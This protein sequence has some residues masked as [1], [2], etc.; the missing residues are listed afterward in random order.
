MGQEHLNNKSEKK[1]KK[2]CVSHN[3]RRNRLYELISSKLQKQKDANGQKIVRAE[4]TAWIQETGG[5]AV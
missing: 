1:K 4:E 3:V 5:L 2:R